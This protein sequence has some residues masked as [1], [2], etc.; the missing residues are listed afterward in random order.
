MTGAKLPRGSNSEEMSCGKSF[1]HNREDMTDR[2]T[3]D[4]SEWYKIV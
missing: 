4:S 1:K 2:E 3:R